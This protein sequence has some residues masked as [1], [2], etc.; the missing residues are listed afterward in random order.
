MRGMNSGL[1]DLIYLAPLQFKSQ[2]RCAYGKPSSESRVQR[3]L[4][5]KLN[6]IDNA[7]HG[8]IAASLTSQTAGEVAGDSMKPYVVYMAIHILE[9]KRLLKDTGSLYLHV[10][11]L[12]D[13]T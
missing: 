7:W 8:Y 1:I 2:L 5:V 6:D 13:I 4:D 9:M 10:I 3:Y 11:L 12:L